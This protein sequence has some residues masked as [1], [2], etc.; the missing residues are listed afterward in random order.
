MDPWNVRMHACMCA[1]MDVYMFVCFY[2]CMNVC[3][4]ACMYAH[5]NVCIPFVNGTFTT[6]FNNLPVNL[7]QTF[8]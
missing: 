6:H 8:F 3:M 2:V 5:A 4:Y 7:C 1:C